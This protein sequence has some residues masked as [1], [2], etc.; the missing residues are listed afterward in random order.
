MGSE[1]CIRDRTKALPPAARQAVIARMQALNKRAEGLTVEE[2]DGI[3]RLMDRMREAGD[4]TL[5]G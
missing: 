5:D 1:M 3:V 4:P 2:F